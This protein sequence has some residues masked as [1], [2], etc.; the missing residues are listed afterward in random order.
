MP[1][2]IELKAYCF[3][4]YEA[5]DKAQKI[6]AQFIKVMK[7][8]DTYY[9]TEKS[10]LKLREIVGESSELIYYDRQLSDK[11]LS[12]YIIAEINDTKNLKKIL[13]MLYDVQVIVKKTRQLF[14]IE[15]AR[16]HFDEVEGLGRY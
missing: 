7:Q 11:W 9:L 12:D 5:I 16:I 8:T 10:K 3:N 4:F 14:L 2:N 1:S 15:N 13:E 6:G